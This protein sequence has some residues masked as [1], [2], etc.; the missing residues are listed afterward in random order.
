MNFNISKE[1]MLDGMLRMN[2]FGVRLTGS[3]SHQNFIDYI[4]AE[5]AKMGLP[6][7]SDPFYFRRW[8]E[9]S[10]SIE[11]LDG[12]AMVNIP[13]SSAYPYSGE[14]SEKGI[15]GEL[16]FV[17]KASKL[18]KIKGKIAVFEI[19]NVNFLPSEIACDKRSES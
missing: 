7:F 5:I 8:E 11:I 9:K 17:D 14:T 2:S 1:E 19:S 15:L 16:V 13:V 3:K 6:V 12:N 4:K 18:A 10:S